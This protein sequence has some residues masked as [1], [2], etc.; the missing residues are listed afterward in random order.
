MYMD[1]GEFKRLLQK[2]PML[3]VHVP[4]TKRVAKKALQGLS[5]DRQANG[6]SRKY[7]NQ[8]VFV[9]ADGFISGKDNES[10]HGKITMKFDSCKEYYRY[11]QLSEEEKAGIISE[12]KTQ[13]KLIIQ[14]GFRY[15]NEAIRPITYLADFAYI[16]DGKQVIEDVKAQDKNTGLYITTEA[17]NLKWKLLKYRYPAYCF[18][19][20]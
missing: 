19:I 14:E 16:R 20:F 3:K 18:E 7:H 8:K 12:L 5:A 4:G 17:F 1:E 10:A 11:L 15:G 9:Y 13:K 6:N 2:N